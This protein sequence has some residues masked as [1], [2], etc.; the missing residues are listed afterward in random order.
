MIGRLPLPALRPSNLL[1]FYC[2]SLSNALFILAFLIFLFSPLRLL[3]LLLSL[4]LP[5]LDRGTSASPSL[6]FP[7]LLS[8]GHVIFRPPRAP[9]RPPLFF[10]PALLFCS[11]PLYPLPN[12]PLLNLPLS[13][14][15]CF[16]FFS[17]PLFNP[18]SLPL[19]PSS[20]SLLHSSPFPSSTFTLLHILPFSR[21]PL[22]FR[23][24]SH[25]S[26]A[27]PPAAT[28]LALHSS[29]ASHSIP[30]SAGS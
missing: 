9:T 20:S 7:V 30:T 28:V 4:P 19:L 16:P 14:Y 3:P 8:C 26:L 13:Q 2:P 21:N 25:F 10:S 29:S 17:L 1:L 24:S 22:N 27:R 6:F 12:P 11:P 23:H 5:R 18:Y 15:P